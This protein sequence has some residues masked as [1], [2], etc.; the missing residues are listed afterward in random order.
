MEECPIIKRTDKMELIKTIQ[1]L[2]AINHDLIRE[3]THIRKDR[4]YYK[5][6]YM[7]HRERMDKD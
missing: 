2:H 3:N 6:L 1:E 7:E 4:D 5:D